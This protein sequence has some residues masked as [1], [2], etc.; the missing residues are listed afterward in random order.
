VRRSYT[1]SPAPQDDHSIGPGELRKGPP[2]PRRIHEAIGR[3][4]PPV[5]VAQRRMGPGGGGPNQIVINR[6][7]WTEDRTGHFPISSLVGTTARIRPETAFAGAGSPMRKAVAKVKSKDGQRVV[8][9]T[10]LI[11]PP[12]NALYE[13]SRPTS[14]SE[15]MPRGTEDTVRTWS[16]TRRGNRRRLEILRR[17]SNSDLTEEYEGVYGIR[18]R[19]R[20]FS[21]SSVK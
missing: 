10:Y 18:I 1:V 5:F 4:L 19:P 13:V 15:G 7:Y 20:L 14:G 3:R 16:R 8:Q 17:K 21:D 6:L 9:A 12:P 11:A 2:D